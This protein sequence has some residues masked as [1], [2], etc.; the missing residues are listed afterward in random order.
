[1]EQNGVG[2]RWGVREGGCR[3]HVKKLECQAEEL[4][5]SLRTLGSH[6]RA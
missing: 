6:D 4:G 1:M 3:T 2:G 5:L